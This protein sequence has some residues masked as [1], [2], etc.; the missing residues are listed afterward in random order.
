MKIGLLTYHCQPNF[1]AQLQS[2][3]TVG[4]LRRMGHDVVVLNWYPADLEEMYARRV[5]KEQ[6][7]CHNRFT[8]E[9]LP[10]SKKC[11]TEEELIAEI[12]TLQ[13]DAIIA[14]SDALFKYYPLNKRRHFS[15]RHLRYLN[16]HYQP[17]SC[18]RLEGNPF[19]GKFISKLKQPI[20]AAAYA[21]SSQNCPFTI[22][23]S[24]EKKQMAEA[25]ANYQ[26]ISVR[27]TWTQQMISSITQN[28]DISIY[29]D[30]VFSFN[31]NYYQSVPTKEEILRKYQLEN[32][33]MLLSFSGKR[34]S[35]D[36]LDSL[37]SE[38]TKNKIQPVALPM[39]ERLYS[40]S[41]KKIIQLPLSPIDWYALIK[42]SCG[43]IGERMHPIVVCLH[44]AVPFFSFDEYGNKGKKSWFSNELIYKPTSSKTYLIVS[45]A[46]LLSNLF[47]YQDAKGLPDSK[48]IIDRILAFDTVK[49]QEFATQ[50]Q[51]AYERGMSAIISVIEKNKA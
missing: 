4:Y 47:S 25:L 48:S 14:G 1:G 11:K 40:A 16:N 50:K 28:K 32:N 38:I 31:Q 19:F 17:L 33:Y 29:P 20:P 35:A 22:M 39:P 2:A 30:P 43:Y 37:A 3:S 24:K 9:V 45:E 8:H 44:N 51:L 10:I 49:C 18:E 34:I 7:D 27:D 26:T 42:Y 36:Y 13:L 15:F 6:I 46:A 23:T 5:P 12:E 21:I 41:I